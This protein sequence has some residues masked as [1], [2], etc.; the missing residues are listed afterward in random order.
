MDNPGNQLTFHDRPY[1]L[2]F[3]GAIFFVM[4]ALILFAPDASFLFGLLF[5][6]AGALILMLTSSLTVTADKTTRTLKL[7]HR[8]LLRRSEK[9]VPFGEIAAIDVEMSL[10]SSRRGSRK[11]RTPSY[12]ITLRTHNGETIPFRGY[13]SGGLNLHQTRANQLRAFIGVGGSD[14]V[15]PSDP[16]EMRTQSYEQIHR[17]AQ[18]SVTGSQAEE[19]VTNGVRWRL[20]THSFGNAP[21][22]RW[23]SPDFKLDNGFIYIA[24]VIPGQK[25]STGG[26]LGGLSTLL[27]KQSASL[28]GFSAADT[29]GMDEAQPMQNPDPRLEQHFMVFTSNQAAARQTL[30]PWVTMPLVNWAHKNPMKQGQSDYGNQLIALYGPNGV[31]VASLGL[32]TPERLQEITAI[33]VE[34]VKSQV[35]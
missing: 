27:F 34:L 12:R 6:G 35:V 17:D 32:A 3:F 11:R 21:I 24:Q 19:Q 10:S 2:W 29:P 1:A 18:E 8:S 14:M 22:T 7:T 5:G 23:V 31:T 25:A 4:G 33:G 16:V 20:E 28:Y 13:Y 15:S 30:N 26:L 9:A